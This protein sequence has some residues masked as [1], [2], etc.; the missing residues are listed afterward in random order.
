VWD[1][2]A[3]AALIEKLRPVYAH[4]YCPADFAKCGLLLASKTLPLRGSVF[5]RFQGALGA[6]KALFD[7]G[8]AGTLVLV[9]PRGAP[10]TAPL[11]P[12]A[13][14]LINTHTQSDFWSSGARRVNMKCLDA[15]HPSQPTD[16]RRD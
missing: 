14:A 11:R 1:T 10:G 7:K 9:H 12:R 13:L 5:Y 15:L 16:E 3:R 4:L 8:C 2:R 6:E